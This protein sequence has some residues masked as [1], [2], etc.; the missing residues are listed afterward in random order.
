[1]PDLEGNIMFPGLWSEPDLLDFD[2][3]PCL[4]RLSLTFSPLVLI[5]AKVHQLADRRLG[6][7]GH[8]Y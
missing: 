5:L 3:F 4:A 2:V 7:R 1:L 6:I 8:L